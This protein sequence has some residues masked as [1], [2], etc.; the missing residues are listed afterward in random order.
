MGSILYQEQARTLIRSQGERVTKPRIQTLSRL[1]EHSQALTHG[2]LR[3][4]MPDLNRVSLYRSLE[5]LIE[6]KL[7]LRIDVDGHHRYAACRYDHQSNHS[8]HFHCMVCGRVQC[9]HN[10]LAPH[11]QLPPGFVVQRAELLVSGVCEKCA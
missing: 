9:L 10:D 1:L 3:Q 11:V 2:E 4:L 6:Q 7:V 8:A 5:W